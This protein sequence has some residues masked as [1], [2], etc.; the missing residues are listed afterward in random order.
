MNIINCISLSN[1]WTDGAN[2][3]RDWY[4]LEILCQ[5]LTRQLN[6]MASNSRIPI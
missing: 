3:P 4:L 2:Q 6:G 1:G 5:L